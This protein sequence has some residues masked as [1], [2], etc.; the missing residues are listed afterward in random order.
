MALDGVA[1]S[2]EYVVSQIVHGLHRRRHV[3]VCTW[4]ALALVYGD[5]LICAKKTRV[6]RNDMGK[7]EVVEIQDV[8]INGVA[9]GRVGGA[10]RAL[11]LLHDEPGRH[12]H[13]GHC[14]ELV[15]REASVSAC[16]VTAEVLKR[17]RTSVVGVQRGEEQ[18]TLVA[19]HSYEMDITTTNYFGMRLGRIVAIAQGA[20]LQR[21]VV[22]CGE[23]NFNVPGEAPW[24][25]VG[26]HGTARQGPAAALVRSAGCSRCSSRGPHAPT[27]PARCW[28]AASKGVASQLMG[29][30]SCR[31]RRARG[32]AATGCS[33]TEIGRATSPR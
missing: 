13:R 4:N 12:A 25:A 32:W 31:S 17:G 14:I 21:I 33:C 20:A 27:R 24:R 18:A 16:T 1:G 23:F 7:D 26:G 19:L 9:H 10:S 28:R 5:S 30:S 11:G 2:D 29:G 15:R 8:H 3:R 22:P 6:L